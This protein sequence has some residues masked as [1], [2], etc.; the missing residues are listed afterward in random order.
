[1]YAEEATRVSWEYRPHLMRVVNAGPVMGKVLVTRN[2]N[3]AVSIFSREQL[4]DLQQ[5]CRYLT[6][7]GQN[8]F[9]AE[10]RW[11]MD[12]QWKFLAVGVSEWASSFQHVLQCGVRRIVPIDHL[13]TYMIHHSVNK[14][15]RRRPRH[16]LLNMSSWLDV[17]ANLSEHPVSMEE[18][19]QEIFEQFNMH[20]MRKE[21]YEGRVLATWEVD[22]EGV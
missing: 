16:E 7:I 1:M 12:R 10:L 20:L 19:Y 6:D 13:Q 4:V 14:A 11:A 18:A 15:Q 9:Y 8:H 17:I 21:Q 3:Q 2:M 22:Q 5:R